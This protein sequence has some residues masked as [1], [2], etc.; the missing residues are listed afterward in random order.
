[1]DTNGLKCGGI[2]ID[3][4]RPPSAS[5]V[6]NGE[7]DLVS[8]AACAVAGSVA[9]SAA[10]A[11]EI[12][13]P[14]AR[15]AKRTFTSAPLRGRSPQLRSQRRQERPDSFLQLSLDLVALQAAE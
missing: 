2:P 5:G 1:M 3:L 7:S 12:R 9:S 6:S 8:V 14:R 4:M 15:T 11:G 13:Q 10:I